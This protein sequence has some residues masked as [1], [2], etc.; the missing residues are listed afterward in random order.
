MDQWKEFLQEMAFSQGVSALLIA[1]QKPSLKSK[2]KP[3]FL[4]VFKAIKIAFG[5][6]PDFQAVMNG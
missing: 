6:D 1:L 3:A 5:D 2:L 4:K